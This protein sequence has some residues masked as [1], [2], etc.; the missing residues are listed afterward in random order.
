MDEQQIHQS[1]EKAGRG[2]QEVTAIDNE[3]L[4]KLT[5]IKVNEFLTFLPVLKQ[6]FTLQINHFKGGRLAHFCHEWEKI[7]SDREILDIVRGQRIEFDT[8]PFQNSPRSQSKFT[9]AE[10]AVIRSEI[11]K[12]V[13][14]SVIVRTQHEPGEFISS[15]FVR[16]KKD[17][18]N[19]MILNLKYLNQHVQYFHFKMET[20]ID[21]IRLMTPNCFM[22][23]IDLKDA[24][25]SVP[26]ARSHQRFL[27]FEWEGSLYAFTCFPNGLASC[28][29][30]FTKLLKPVYSV[31]RQL[32]HLSSPYIDDSYLQGEDY[33]RCLE[34]IIDT[35]RLLYTLGFIVH[36]EKSV[37]IPTQRLI[38]LGFILDSILM[39]IYMTP[40]KVNKVIDM[41]SKLLKNTSPTIREVS[42]VLGYLI[43]TFPGVVLGPLYFRHLEAVKSQA[44]KDN[45]GNFDAF[46]SLNKEAEAELAWWIEHAPN[47]YNVVSHGEP[48]IVLTTDASST[49]W[50]CTLGQNRSGG[51]WTKE[52]AQHHIN[53]LE[54]LAVFL[55][56][57]AFS[58]SLTGKHVKVMIDN[59]TALTD[60]NH[61]GTSKSAIR[62]KLTKSV[63]LWCLERNIWLTAVHIPGV[64]NVEADQQSR[65]S[66]TSAEWSLNKDIFQDAMCR[67][68]VKP[69]IDLFA[70]RINYQIKPYV[71]FHPDPGA[72]AVNAFHMSWKQFQAYIFP[73][74]CLISRILQKVQEEQCTVVMVAPRWPTQVWWPK[75]MNQLIARPLLLPK[76]KTTLILPSN[77]EAIHPLYP[78]LELMICHL[79]G[80]HSKIKAFQQLLPTLSPNRGDK[81][82]LNNTDLTSKNG[83]FTV[84]RG[85]LIQFTL[86]Y[87]TD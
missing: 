74:F 59:M 6:H 48:E 23:S 22:G 47:S 73:P 80:N 64:E 69:N 41:C 43:S 13:N 5:N 34:N 27:K 2:Q 29:R 15:V 4:T 7:T 31:L 55:A 35:V 56:L 72:I 71:S 33:D 82:L 49:G 28:P 61:M 60:I 24:Y 25:Y 32:G 9:D 77:P 53:Y 46:M 58:D 11:S 18:T 19:R 42:Q 81:G 78:Q 40:E 45:K 44:L 14:K 63:W 54:L 87:Q 65:L 21:A 85:K 50:G 68:G 86:L 17:G 3:I 36:P 16:P 26:I 70:S 66:N 39:H 12:L 30:K 38:F 75:L 57:Q 67:L 1:S 52:E 8:E 84:V 37:L 76:K 62:N 83:S 79:S 51:Y 20:L 10:Q